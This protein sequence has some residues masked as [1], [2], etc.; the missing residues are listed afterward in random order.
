MKVWVGGTADFV[1]RSGGIGS[2]GGTGGAAGKQGA[3]PPA[4]PRGDSKF[5]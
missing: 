5:R 4:I 3:G 2:E 1:W